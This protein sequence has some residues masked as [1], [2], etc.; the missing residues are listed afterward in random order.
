MS[1]NAHWGRLF[2]NWRKLYSED[3]TTRASGLRYF[4]GF[5]VFVPRSKHQVEYTELYELACII[6]DNIAQGK[7]KNGY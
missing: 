4:R 7:Y 6:V 1:E 5:A 2:K 3:E